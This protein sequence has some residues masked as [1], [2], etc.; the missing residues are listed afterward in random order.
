MNAVSLVMVAGG[1]VGAGGWLAWSGLAP[2]RPPLHVVLGRLGRPR[3]VDEAV[4]DDLDARLGAMAR[5]IGV[6]DQA[7]ESLR[8]DLRI[9]RGSPDEQ[10]AILVT[11]AV[12][13][14][15]WLPVVSVGGWLVGV[16]LPLAIPLWGALLGGG[17]GVWTA[18]RSTREAARHRRET[19]ARALSALCD[20]CG[21]CLAA[22]RGV[23]SSLETAASAGHG[24]AF[25]E[26]QSALRTGYVRGDEPWEAL[27]Q[28]GEEADLPDLVELAGALSLAGHE[29]AAVRRTVAQKARAIRE[30][31]TSEAERQAASTTERMGVPATFLL[32]GF[33]VFLGF[34]A[35]AVLFE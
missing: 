12:L 19:F 32:L 16:R 4:T 33:V 30:R 20:V 6:V 11:Y 28:L 25:A 15:L 8:S 29:G 27:A 1:L 23:E 17:I 10:A 34:P 24:W 26:I 13:G 2:A 9:L 5:R 18:I 21:M 7:V 3:P 22:G 31:L 35:I 14:L